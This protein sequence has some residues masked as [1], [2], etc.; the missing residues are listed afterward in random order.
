MDCFETRNHMTDSIDGT[1]P[2][3][4]RQDFE[5]HL[6]DC[7]PC[8]KQSGRLRELIQVMHGQNRAAIPLELRDDP[9]SFKLPALP[10]D[11][12]PKAIW[13]NLPVWV[14]LIIEGVAIACVVSLGIQVGP[15]IRSFYEHRMDQRLQTMIAAEDLSNE[16]AIPLSRGKADPESAHSDTEFASEESEETSGSGEEVVVDPNLRVGRGEI[17][18]FNIKTD[19]PALVRSKIMKA[20]ADSGIPESTAGFGGIEAPGGIQFDLIAPQSAIPQLKA[21]LEKLAAPHAGETP[22][23]TPFSDTFTWYKNRSKKPIPSGTSRVV[24]WLS[25]I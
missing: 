1:L 21:Q 4:V 15:Q 12:N 23:D 5:N 24:I 25:Q 16:G 7:D 2:P 17:W 13:K 18:R 20:F 22:G 11:K 14:R 6:K 8:T 10:F 3:G 9:L 19:S